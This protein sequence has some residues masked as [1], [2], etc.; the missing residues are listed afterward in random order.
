MSQAAGGYPV[1]CS[2]STRS[3]GRW[4]PDHSLHGLFLGL[5]SLSSLIACPAIPSSTTPKGS[6]GSRH[7]SKSCAPGA[8]R[9]GGRAV[10]ARCG[11]SQPGGS[12]FLLLP[13]WPPPSLAVMLLRAWWLRS[14]HLMHGSG[15][16]EGADI[17]DS[18]TQA[19]IPAPSTLPSPKVFCI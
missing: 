2:S 1:G 11:W 3:E 13:L 18:R 19:S 15:Q 16:E 10:P 4:R 7:K 12:A 8:P 5:P 17:G 9:G 6:Q 14:A